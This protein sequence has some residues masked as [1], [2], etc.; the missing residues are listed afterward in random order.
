ML[1]TGDEAVRAIGEFACAQGVKGASFTALG[2]FER[3]MPGHLDWDHERYE[4]IRVDDSARW[5]PL[6]GRLLDG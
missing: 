4:P 3:A 2:A 5:F 6:G 1:D